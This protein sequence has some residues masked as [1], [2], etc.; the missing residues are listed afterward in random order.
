MTTVNQD[1]APVRCALTTTDLEQQAGNLTNWSQEYD[2]LSAGEFLGR[3][4]KVHCRN[5]HVFDEYTNRQLR[6]QCQIWPDAI[7]FGIPFDSASDV[8]INGHKMHGNSILMHASDHAFELMT[9]EDFYIYGLVFDGSTLDRLSLIQGVE[10]R[11]T[12][13]LM[14]AVTPLKN[15]RI[16]RLKLFLRTII[17]EQA[18]GLQ[19]DLRDDFLM[20]YLLESVE[21]DTQINASLRSYSHR[22]AVVDRVKEYIKEHHEL[23]VTINELCS[24]AYVSRRTLQYS[25]E[26]ILGL[27]PL[28]FLR[29]TRLNQVRR[30]LKTAGSDI[31]V[32]EV[33]EKWGFFH[34]GQFGHDYKRLFGETPSETLKK[35]AF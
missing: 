13:R 21:M 8:R 26:S 12:Q 24:I 3:V 31:T 1:G 33:A 15:E 32:T 30:D 11:D 23:P 17:D 6:Q 27:S 20:T 16:Q 5:V 28:K 25:F 9:P 29:L 19:A 2:Q 4:N 34:A 35:H 22:K 18:N 14:Q 7:W 10:L